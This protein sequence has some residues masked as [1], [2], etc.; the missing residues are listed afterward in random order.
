[1]PGYQT[2]PYVDGFLETGNYAIPRVKTKLNFGDF[3]GTLR[4]RLG[5]ARSNY[6]V[7][8]GLYCI[9][10]PSSKSPVLVTANYKLSFDT[11]RGNLQGEDAW[12]LVVDTRGINVWC[13]A[14]KG[15]FSANE[16]AL[17]VGR[18]ILD[19]IVT[20]RELILPQFAAAG[21]ASHELKEK[22]GFIGTYGPIRSQDLPEY[23]GHNNQADERMRS[24]TFTLGE[25]L[26]LTPVEMVLTWKIVLLIA[27]ASFIISGVNPDIYSLEAVWSRGLIAIGATMA[28]LLAGTLV[29]PVLLPWIPGR[30]FWLKGALVGFLIGLGYQFQF[31]TEAQIVEQTAILL[32]ITAASSYLA[33]NFTG[34]TPYTSLSGV[35]QEMRKGLP[36]QCIGAVLS[37]LLWLSAPFLL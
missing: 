24:V 1:M 27:P 23:L 9:G 30:Q 8:P 28:A 16:I 13:A 11:L 6:K 35:E 19:K 25:R 21:V 22:C 3:L 32:W 12:I 15:T 10:T 29:T 17:Q 26:I 20:H 14:G 5:I 7:N 33:M 37:I 18:T 34:A 2:E 36:F 4:V 31:M